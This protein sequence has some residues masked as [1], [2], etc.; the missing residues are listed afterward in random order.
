MRPLNS[1][2][3][4]ATRT[5]PLWTINNLY[6]GARSSELYST[7]KI[8]TKIKAMLYQN[9]LNLSCLERLLIALFCVI[10]LPRQPK[11]PFFIPP[12][13]NVQGEEIKLNP[14]MDK[15][16]VWADKGCNGSFSHFRVTFN[17]PTL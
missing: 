8:K 3:V 2:K 9:L 4:Q 12:P 17:F 14:D 10:L 16:A 6:N 1:V 15:S 7:L 5:S 13:P 11:R